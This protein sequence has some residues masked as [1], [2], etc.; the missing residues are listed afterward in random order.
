MTTFTQEQTEIDVYLSPIELQAIFN[1]PTRSY[2]YL[3]KE[4]SNLVDIITEI[5]KFDDNHDSAI[6]ALVEHVDKGFVIGSYDAIAQALEEA[7]LV[8]FEHRSALDKEKA[9]AL[10]QTLNKVIDQVID[11]KLNVDADSLSFLKDSVKKESSDSERHGCQ[12][13]R[14]LVVEEKLEVCG[15]A[16]F[17]DD[18][19][20]EDDV[21]FKKDVTFAEHAGFKHSVTFRKNHFC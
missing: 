20:F 18:V 7:E 12:G 13:L 10:T 5:S 19:I 11:D 1:N 3:G 9:S 4:A 15:K 17:K 16:K 6:H 14:L 2:V 21:F 8:L